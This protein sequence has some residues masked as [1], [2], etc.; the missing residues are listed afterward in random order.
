MT[1]HIFVISPLEIFTGFFH[2][3][4][5]IE[6]KDSVNLMLKIFPIGVLTHCGKN[7]TY[8]GLYNWV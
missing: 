8:C 2:P 7:V 6:K 4:E 1:Q 3:C 5:T